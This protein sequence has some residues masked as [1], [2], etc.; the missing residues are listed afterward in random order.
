MVSLNLVPSGYYPAGTNQALEPVSSTSQARPDDQ[1]GGRQ[2]HTSLLPAEARISFEVR[3]QLLQ[4]KIP[5]DDGISMKNRQ[6]LKAY[7]SF[8]D[9]DERELVSRMMGVDEYA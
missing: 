3:A 1:Q 8:E 5:L 4:Q 6:A 2:S 7:R 9:Q